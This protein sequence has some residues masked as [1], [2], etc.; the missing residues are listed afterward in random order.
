MAPF[1]GWGSIASRLEPLQGGILIFTFKCKKS[2]LV[3]K[4]FCKKMPQKL[5]KFHKSCSLSQAARMPS[6]YLKYNFCLLRLNSFR[7]VDS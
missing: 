3:Q 5:K 2:C 7:H 1:N 4:L 6:T